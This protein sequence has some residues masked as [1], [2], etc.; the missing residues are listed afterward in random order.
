MIDQMNPQY[1]HKKY[2]NQLL[3]THF[4]DGDSCNILNS[5]KAHFKNYVLHKND[6][7]T[8]SAIYEHK[9]NEK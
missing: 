2:F 7:Y 6:K 5:N 1:M 8:I 9:M 3:P 4:H